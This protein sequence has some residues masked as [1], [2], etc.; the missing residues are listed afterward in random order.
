MSEETIKVN[1]NTDATLEIDQKQY[2]TGVKTDYLRIN[3]P[4]GRCIAVHMLTTDHTFGTVYYHDTYES[5][6]AV[7]EI[8]E[9]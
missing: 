8:I 6:S 3:L 2:S 5:G 7:L 1:M 9:F 4:D